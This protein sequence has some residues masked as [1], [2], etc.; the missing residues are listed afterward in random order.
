MEKNA[1]ADTHR[2]EELLQKDHTG[3]FNSGG[4]RRQKGVADNA[5]DQMKA[6]DSAGFNQKSH[7]CDRAA[8]KNLD[9][10]AE[11]SSKSVGARV[12]SVY[13]N[14]PP[15]DTLVSTSRRKP[16]VQQQFYRSNL[17]GSL[18]HH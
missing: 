16:V 3:V 8:V 2:A 12:S 5:Y 13:G 6:G 14:R 10:H 9:I 18:A 4:K 7:R 1:L 17:D 11:E 15:I